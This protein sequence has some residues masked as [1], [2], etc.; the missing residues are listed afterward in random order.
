[1]SV[2]SKD[3][4]EEVLRSH[5][6]RSSLIYFHCDERGKLENIRIDE[7]GKFIW[8]KLGDNPFFLYPNFQGGLGRVGSTP[9]K[10]TWKKSTFGTSLIRGAR[11][12]QIQNW[13]AKYL[14]SI[15]KSRLLAQPTSNYLGLG[16]VLRHLRAK[17]G[18]SIWLQLISMSNRCL[19]SKNH[20]LLFITQIC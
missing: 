8:K 15:V 14:F 11:G 5:F 12:D 10:S 17:M 4:I 3:V 7:R 16:P 6:P 9:P 18:N 1:M 13:P 19:L 20:F 2:G